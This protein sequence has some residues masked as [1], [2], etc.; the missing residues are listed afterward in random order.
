[1]DHSKE[2]SAGLGAVNSRDP[3]EAKNR[4]V[5]LD[6]SVG[7]RGNL[8][9]PRVL[10]LCKSSINVENVTAGDSIMEVRSSSIDPKNK[11]MPISNWGSLVQFPTKDSIKHKLNPPPKLIKNP[12]V[13][14]CKTIKNGPVLSQT[15]TANLPKNRYLQSKMKRP[16]TNLGSSTNIESK[17]E[18]PRQNSHY[19]KNLYMHDDHNPQMARSFTITDLGPKL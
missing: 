9:L 14:I 16:D 17:K 4:K 7:F 3:Y 11:S 6:R 12:K 2:G 15:L 19:L 13:T 10:A 18:M 8:A 1:M 5:N